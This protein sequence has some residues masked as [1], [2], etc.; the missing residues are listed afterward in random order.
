MVL[1]LYSDKNCEYQSISCIRSLQGKITDDVKIVYYTIDFDSDFEFHNLHKVRIPIKPEYPRY[2]FY[3]ADLSILTMDLFPDDYYAFTDTDV[4]FSKRFSFDN[5]KNEQTYPMASFGPHE[6]P[7][8]YEHVNEQMIIY[9]ERKMMEYFNVPNRT[10]RYVWSCF[11]TYN[12]SCRDFFEEYI[13]MC[14]NQYLQ[15]NPKDYFPYA[16]ETAFNVCLWKRNATINLGHAFVNTHSIN[17][18]K[19]VEENQLKNLHPNRN[20]DRFGADWEY[21]ENSDNVILYHGFKDKSDIDETLDYLL[22]TGLDNKKIIILNAYPNSQE[23]IDILKKYILQLKKTNIPIL[24]SSHLTIPTDIIQ[25]VDFYLYDKEN[26]ILPIERCP[27]KWFATDNEYIEF[28]CHRHSL[29][30]TRSMNYAINFVKNMGYES[31]LFTEYDN[32]LRDSDVSKINQLFVTLE[33]S[34]KK[35]LVFN[36]KWDWDSE[37]KFIYQ[38]SMFCANTSYFL[39]NVPL[40]KTYEEWNTTYPYS[41]HSETLEKIFTKILLTKS[42]E[43]H[44]VQ[45]SD[46]EYFENSTIDLYHS[47]MSDINNSIVYNIENPQNPLFFVIADE[48]GN[49]EL[50]LNNVSVK[51]TI[52]KKDE[53]FMYYFEIPKDGNVLIEFYKNQKTIFT[54][55]IDKNIIE[56]FKGKS[57]RK[58]LNA[59]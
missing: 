4:L 49:Y 27:N 55:I 17:I 42:Q 33:Q 52:H 34:N 18:V 1:F 20:V 15:K 8:I 16:D 43:V 48:D 23:K 6:Y 28:T 14:K 45:K 57:I 11:Y 25:L 10:Q 2:H 58:S 44:D 36:S 41:T 5:I 39:D 54:K 47:G 9:N 40:P 50:K 19:F 13:S 21:I 56:E 59:K 46:R 12:P 51:N 38:T 35:I 26:L 22:K 7:F 53:W 29:A 37:I 30:I 3:K 31:F 32:E 24:L